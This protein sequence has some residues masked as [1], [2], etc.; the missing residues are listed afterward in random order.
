MENSLVNPNFTSL[1]DW[2]YLF[3]ITT[4]WLWKWRCQK[5]FRNGYSIPPDCVTFLKNQTKEMKT[6]LTKTNLLNLIR[7]Q[8]QEVLIGWNPPPYEWLAL[9]TDGAAKG[10][11]GEAG[12]GGIFRDHTGKV[13]GFFS[14]KL[15][16]CSAI[17]AEFCAILKG[18]Q[19][20]RQKGIN[21]LE[22]RI[23][24][25]DF[26]QVLN[27]NKNYMGPSKQIVKRCRELLE[28][29]GWI[30]VL[31]HCYRE[32]NFAADWL[33]NHGVKQEEELIVHDTPPYA[34][35]QIIQQDLVGVAWA[36]K[37]AL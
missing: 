1:E 13:L 32:A 27:Y 7:M 9:N 33:A 25:Q 17:H 3:P 24:N 2:L 36:R 26:V 34:L 6:A 15:G 10:T 11:P 28:L 12:A 18:L 19:L 22:V 20:A 5:V 8:R 30:V 23:D 35:A 37:V 29:D 31:S 14:Q 21:K 4:W 16:I